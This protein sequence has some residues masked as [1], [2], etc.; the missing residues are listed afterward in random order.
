M[1]KK[2]DY[3]NIAAVL[4]EQ[5]VNMPGF[6]IHREVSIFSKRRKTFISIFLGR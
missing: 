6:F 3:L 1:E 2:D 5:L 4:K